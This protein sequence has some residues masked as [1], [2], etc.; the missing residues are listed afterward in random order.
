MKKPQ[1]V[2]ATQEQLDGLLALAKVAFPQPQ[3]ELLERVLETFV[4]VMQALQNAKT[5]LTRFRHMLFGKRTEN[6]RG[7]LKEIG[8]DDGDCANQ[9]STLTMPGD[10]AALA[11]LAAPSDGGD[12]KQKAKGHGRNG[13]NAYRGAGV[14]ACKHPDVRPGDRCP[15]CLVGKLYLSEPKTIVKVSG[16]LPL[17][18]TVY[19]LDRLRCRLCDTIF[20]A[21]MPDGVDARKYDTSCA[22]MIAMLR[23]GSGMPFHRL[24]GLQGCLHVPLPDATQWDIVNQA[25]AA[26]RHVFHELI[27]QAAQA[28]VLHNDDTPGRILALMGVRRAK[29]EAAGQETPRTKAINTTGIVALLGEQKQKVVLFFTGP[30]HAGQNLVL[31]LAHRAKELAAPT[32]M[33][34]ALTANSKGDFETDL[35]HCIAHGRRQF[36]EVA[37]HFPAPCRRVIEDLATVYGID[38]HCKDQKMSDEQRLVYHQDNSGPLMLFLKIWMY[39]QLAQRLVE[40][41]SSLGQAL[42]YMIKHWREM[43]LFL[44]KTGAP[45]DNNI[46]ERAL[47][48]A[49]IHRKNS[50]FYRSQQGAE[51]GDIYMSLIYTCQQ[52]GANPFEYLQALQKH[53]EDVKDNARQWLPWNYRAALAATT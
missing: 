44:R 2:D 46:A 37:E 16:Q 52:C 8:C 25:A 26:P 3:Y 6:K 47:K 22:S 40:P 29:T 20:T 38:A 32:Q 27:K 53:A 21:P 10:P 15:E 19:T 49:I 28:E 45:L 42:R 4:Y 43:T 33:C 41:N 5:S 31:V 12:K 48:K 18:A 23:Y 11:A 13:A 35:R 24:E 17:G 34:D 50:L 39:E 9:A 36:V 7:I 1:L 14:V 30:A 51:V